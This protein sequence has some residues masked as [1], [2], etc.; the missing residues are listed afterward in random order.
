MRLFLLACALLGLTSAWAQSRNDSWFVGRTQ[1]ISFSNGAPQTVLGQP[2]G[3]WRTASLSDPNGQRLVYIAGSELFNRN[4]QHVLGAPVAFSAGNNGQPNVILPMPGYPQR[5]VVFGMPW[6]PNASRLEYVTVDMSLDNGLG[7]S[8]DTIF[9]RVTNYTHR[10]GGQFTAVPHANGTDYWVVMHEEGSDAFYSFLL[11]AQGVDTVPVI[12][13]SGS[14]IP[15]AH[16]GGMMVASY[17]GDRIALSTHSGD[18]PAPDD[19]SDVELFSFDAANGTLGFLCNLPGFSK[20]RSVEFSPLG[21]KLYVAEQY[22][23]PAVVL[24]LWQYD[25]TGTNCVDIEASKTLIWQDTT[26]D[27]GFINSFRT[28]GLAPDGRIYHRNFWTQGYLGVVNDPDATGAACGYVRDG[29]L[30]MTDTLWCITN[31]CKRYHDSDSPWTGLREEPTSVSI[32]LWPM[33]LHDQGWLRLDPGVV[34]DELQW[35]DGLGRCVRHQRTAPV[36]GLPINRGT[37]SAGVFAI[38]ILRNSRALGV[39]RVVVE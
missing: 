10:P 11:S 37:L 9:N 28:L 13:H 16:F 22:Q 30:A 5:L 17:Q 35:I 27:S 32:T 4:D 29:F 21:T 3:A 12:T 31:Q 15:A 24:E 1:W 39:L 14:V 6:F 2:R 26:T 8:L 23:L 33:P 7:G 34:F 25:L 19:S 36:N 20:P 38:R 18:F